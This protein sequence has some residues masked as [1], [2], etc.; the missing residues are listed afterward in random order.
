MKEW[1]DEGLDMIIGGVCTFQDISSTSRKQDISLT[2]RK[3]DISLTSRKQD[4]SWKLQEDKDP[5][6]HLVLRDLTS[7]V[8]A[9]CSK[10]N[11]SVDA[12]GGGGVIGEYDVML[13]GF[14]LQCCSSL[15]ELTSK[16]DR[17]SIS[18]G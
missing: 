13:F 12:G 8:S 10:R 2:P 15:N 3:Q 16:V 5:P 11:L 17:I 14:C 9:L 6:A 4:I 1:M 7:A 18:W